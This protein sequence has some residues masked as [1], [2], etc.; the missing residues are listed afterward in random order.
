M[1]LQQDRRRV[2]HRDLGCAVVSARF[3]NLQGAVLS[4]GLRELQARFGNAAENQTRILS[5]H[6]AW[7]SKLI[8]RRLRR[9]SLQNMIRGSPENTYLLTTLPALPYDAQHP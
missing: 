5:W 3:P 2:G 1:G 7:R 6:V 8:P 4:H 9:R